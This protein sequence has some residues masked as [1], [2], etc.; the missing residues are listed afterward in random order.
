MS[1]FC[2]FG[3]TRSKATERA[4]K[5]IPLSRK[6]RDSEV[7]E[8]SERLFSTMTPVPVSGQFCAPQFAEEFVDLAKKQHGFRALKV[9]V[10][11]VKRDKHGEKRISKRTG[12]PMIG[13]VRYQG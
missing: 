4:E 10:R 11:D 7:R 8:L 9:M 13:W 5:R 12:K 2:V 3:V 6:D 1:A